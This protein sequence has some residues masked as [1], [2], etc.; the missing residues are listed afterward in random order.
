MIS[1]A[2]DMG[3][4]CSRTWKECSVVRPSSCV[5]TIL[6]VSTDLG[7]TGSRKKR[8][9]LPSNGASGKARSL[10]HAPTFRASVRSE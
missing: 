10:R 9:P 2:G 1:S 8:Y 5:A 6:I 7:C 3:Y 4:G